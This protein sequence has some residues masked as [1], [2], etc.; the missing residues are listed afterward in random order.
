MNILNQ[1]QKKVVL[2]GV[3]IEPGKIG[4]IKKELYE[5]LMTDSTVK[6]LFQDGALVLIKEKEEKTLDKKKEAKV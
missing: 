4:S 5:S 3:H 6:N 1:S 2:A